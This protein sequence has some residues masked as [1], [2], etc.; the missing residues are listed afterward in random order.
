MT[1]L[2]DV[3]PEFSGMCAGK[4]LML[5]FDYDGTLAP[6][7]PTPPQAFLS[8]ENR[9]LLEVLA[10]RCQ[11]IIIS[12]RAL[13]DLKQKV[14]IEGLVYVGNHGLEIEGEDLK[15]EGVVPAEYLEIMASVKEKIA[16]RLSVIAGVLIEDKGLT[17]SVHYRLV[18]PDQFSQVVAAVEEEC[19]EY[20]KQNKISL[21]AGK[22]VIELKPPVTWDKGKA[23][24]WLLEKQEMT[25]PEGRVFPIYVGDDVTDE[26]AFGA[27][28][29]KGTTVF[30][31]EQGPS[32][33]QYYLK[34]PSEVT[35]L[36]GRLPA[37]FSSS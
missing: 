15:F 26:D 30:V 16:E 22:K 24:L 27:L 8:A 32:Q 21:N 29:S 4:R 34:D 9:R 7:Q 3:W 2:F 25:A 19:F 23:S 13:T 11:I 10:R 14:G 35:Q 5:F 37:I 36:L 12:G 18:R 28:K 33:A 20:L 31:G 17:L 6:I 1:H